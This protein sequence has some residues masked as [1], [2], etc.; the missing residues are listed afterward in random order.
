MIRDVLVFLII[1]SCLPFGWADPVKWISCPK[2]ASSP[3]IVN[4][5]K[6]GRIGIRSYDWP[7]SMKMVGSAEPR[8]GDC[9]FQFQNAQNQQLVI[10]F[11]NAHVG[12]IFDGSGAVV[13]LDTTGDEIKRYATRKGSLSAYFGKDSFVGLP[14]RWIGFEAIVAAVDERSD[15]PITACPFETTTTSTVV[16]DAP[17][18]MALSWIT[19]ATDDDYKT[20]FWSY[21]PAKGQILKVFVR[22]ADFH[23]TYERFELLADGETII[24]SGP[25]TM[26]LPET[27]VYATNSVTLLF[28]PGKD[29]KTVGKA[30]QMFAV[31]S[32]FDS[33]TCEKAS[34]S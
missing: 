17:V 14:E 28:K 6:D 30:N 9:A 10:T 16:P 1:S 20:C 11:L 19:H 34:K 31:V 3:L 13:L 18:F 21:A 27:A 4:V 26:N 29:A 24:L 8:F 33:D 12:V 15:A 5:P 25:G 2:N 32:A 7:N 22:F 23:N